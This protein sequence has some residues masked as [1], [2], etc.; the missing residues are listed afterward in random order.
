[1]NAQQRILA[2][3]DRESVDR[4]PVDVWLTPEVLESLMHYT[5]ENDEYQL[6][7]K[8]GVDKIAWIFPGYGTESFDPNDSAG[9]DPW[10]V[11][12]IKVKSGLAT[13][14]E[15][16]KGPLADMDE[17]EEL[18]GYALWPDPEK[19][20]YKAS[21]ALATR[22]R[23]FGFATIGPWVS[24]F[25]TYCHMRG[26]E[27]ALMD[28]IAEPEFLEAGLDRIESIQSVMMER[29]L[30]ELG[31][32]IDVVFIS[33]DL[34][35][36]ASQLISVDQ[37]Q[38]HLQPRLARWCDLIHSHGKKVLFHTDGASRNFVEPLIDSGVDI[39]NPIQHICP[40][41]ER[42]AL[43]KDFGDRVVFH[44]G[45]E[46]QH[47]LPHGSVDDVRNEVKTCLETLGAGGGYI[48]CSCHN[49]QAGTPPEN[50]VAMIET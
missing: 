42:A 1:M 27:N 31:E 29:F 9:Q 14:Q 30:A 49:I 21:Q 35:T 24:H 4:V 37:W 38:C 11:P 40:G 43:N 46:N 32:L 23:D 7:R 22:A 19:F 44:G 6:Y 10:G 28:V 15:Y 34:G 48:P 33:D 50:V 17:P 41:M 47:V 36:Q 25:E 45:V 8:L 2:T 18:D 12:T 16:G 3:L 26:M 13:Y 20:N 39:L 5:G